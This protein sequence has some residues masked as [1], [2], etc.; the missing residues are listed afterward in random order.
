MRWMEP[1]CQYLKHGVS[2]S[3]PKQERNLICKA[4]KY[5]LLRETLYKRSFNWPI[6]KCVD[7]HETDYV[8][9]EV[10]ERMCENHQGGCILAHRIIRQGYYR[11]IIKKD[12]SKKVSKCKACQKNTNLTHQSIELLKLFPLL[13]LSFCS[14]LGNQGIEIF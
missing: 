7:E 5:V 8:M 13:I 14:D 6:L 3:Y 10:Y 4:A 9:R 2:T 11:P 12:C 1:I